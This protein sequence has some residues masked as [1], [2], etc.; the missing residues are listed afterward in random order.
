[1][2]AKAIKGRIGQRLI[3][4][5]PI[6]ENQLELCL[7]EQKKTGEL[8]GKIIQRSGYASEKE[9]TSALADQSGIKEVDIKGIEIEPETLQ[10]MPASFAGSH[11]VI[12]LS[13]KDG[14][15]TI[16]VSDPFDIM[17]VEDLERMTNLRID[18]KV[19]SETDILEAID[20][21]Y[22][23]G[24]ECR[25]GPKTVDD[26]LSMRPE[27]ILRGKERPASAGGPVG[28]LVDQT[29]IQAVQEG[30]TDIHFEPKE[31][32][33]CS[34]FRIDG[35]L[36]EGPGFPK[37]L[38]PAIM[39]RI[40]IMA[41]LNI[42][43]SRL[44]QDGRFM[45]PVDEREID[46][47]VS[48]FPTMFGE[49]MVIR[50]LDSERL[51][52]S[53]ENL[54][55]YSSNLKLFKDMI[56]RPHGIILVCGPT[57]SGKTTSLYSALSHINSGEKN[58]VTL[59]DP[60]EYELPGLSQSQINLKAGFT[61]ASGLRSILR[62]DPDIIFVGEMRDSETV[63]VAMRAAI[64]GH[65]VFSTLHTNDAA[66]AIA[67]LLDMRVEPYLLSSS[68]VAVIAQ[69]LI[70]KVCPY[71]KEPWEPKND[72]LKAMA[73]GRKRKGSTFYRAKGCDKCYGTGYRGRIGVFEIMP[74]SSAISSLI[75]D[76][77]DSET[78]KDQARKEGMITMLEDGLEKASG[79]ITT[80]EEVMRVTQD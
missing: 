21:S 17:T 65:L 54:G 57:G 35:I 10:L 56:L 3:E 58:V 7:K 36:H 71:C 13:R 22:G 76:G 9:V 69:R 68:I 40:K 67:R 19:A 50:I 34:R 33:L 53:L 66:G 27:S 52:L 74:V 4:R 14:R 59:E 80:I 6:S 15:L 49:K 61:F 78:L 38:Q 5:G 41:N 70:R 79:G 29:I 46:F 12:P 26:L 16:A 18:V 11:K 31:K 1:M 42:S 45:F 24:I 43:E 39:T 75:V 2:G 62:Q 32:E 73:S 28:Q 60:V 8:L 63:E 20:R 25:H 44:P 72:I 23:T 30:A 55:L 48:T 64:T 37:N 47:R 77:A 51:I